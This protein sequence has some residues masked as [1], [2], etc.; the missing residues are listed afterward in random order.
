[1]EPYFGA[2]GIRGVTPERIEKWVE[3]LTHVRGYKPSTVRF[4]FNILLSP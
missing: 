1:M 2:D 3:W 4:R